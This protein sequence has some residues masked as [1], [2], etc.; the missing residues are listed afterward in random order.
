MIWALRVQQ[1]FELI[2]VFSG[3]VN[4]CFDSVE[5]VKI[6]DNKGSI[7]LLIK[8]CFDFHEAHDHSCPLM[9]SIIV[10]ANFFWNFCQ[11]AFARSLYDIVLNFVAWINHLCT[12]IQFITLIKVKLTKLGFPTMLSTRSL[13]SPS[14]TIL[15]NSQ[16]GLTAT[17]QPKEVHLLHHD[18]SISFTQT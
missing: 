2:Q 1:T 6:L 17:L 18:A 16:I 7:Q 5:K 11:P 10:F 15:E 13:E 8:H 3:T 14:I 4:F 9:G 12:C